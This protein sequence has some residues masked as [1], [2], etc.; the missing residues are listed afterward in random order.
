MGYCM[1]LGTQQGTNILTT[2]DGAM[3]VTTMNSV[4]EVLRE[5]RERPFVVLKATMRNLQPGAQQG[6]W[7]KR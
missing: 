6:F 7:P 1:I 2:D 5:I 3:V 4:G